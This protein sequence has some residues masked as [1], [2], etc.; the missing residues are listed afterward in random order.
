MS[1]REKDKQAS[2]QWK[3]HSREEKPVFGHEVP[4]TGQGEL[5]H[6]YYP[7]PIVHS[8]KKNYITIEE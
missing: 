4:T 1:G 8:G 2:K 7:F 5:L 6:I 3:F